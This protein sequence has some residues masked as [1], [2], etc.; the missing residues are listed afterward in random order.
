MRITTTL[1]SKIGNKR[2]PVI[3]SG[4]PDNIFDLIFGLDD[5]LLKIMIWEGTGK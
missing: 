3:P 1:K 2:A 5:A 4:K